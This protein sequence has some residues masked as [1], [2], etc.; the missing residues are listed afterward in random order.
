MRRLLPAGTEPSYHLFDAMVSQP[1]GY[2]DVRGTAA[3]K[4]VNMFEV[5]VRSQLPDVA[6]RIS[7]S[8]SFRRRYKR[9]RKPGNPKDLC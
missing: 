1:V 2:E 8:L 6:I 7:P 4:G 5:G 9:L 3:L